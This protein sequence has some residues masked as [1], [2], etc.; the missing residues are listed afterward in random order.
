MELNHKL[1]YKIKIRKKPY[2]R[3]VTTLI[4]SLFGKSKSKENGD[5][6]FH[7]KLTRKRI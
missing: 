1:K 5:E 4:G 2:I 7:Q 3:D 6:G